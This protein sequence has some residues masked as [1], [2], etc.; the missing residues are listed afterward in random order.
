VGAADLA[1]AGLA[2]AEAVGL[3]A[4]GAAALGWLPALANAGIRITASRPPPVIWTQ[5]RRYHGLRP[6]GLSGAGLMVKSDMVIPLFN[7]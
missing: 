6:R 4:A 3:L 2:G 5:R 1:G 7:R